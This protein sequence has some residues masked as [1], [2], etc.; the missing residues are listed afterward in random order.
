MKFYVII[1]SLLGSVLQAQVNNSL[2]SRGASAGRKATNIVSTNTP[3]RTPPNRIIEFMV[4]L[5]PS[6][7]VSVLSSRNPAVEYARA[8][9]AVP[10]GFDPEIPTPILLI[11]STSDG[12]AS[13]IRVMPAF[14]NVALRLGWVV[15]AADPPFGKPQNDSP[16]WR[17]A[18]TS[19]LLEH[20]H[21][22][23]PGSKK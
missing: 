8:A 22:N 13:S 1:L 15:I 5:S 10:L 19:S 16:P 3:Y 6:A 11:C 4:P 7:K 21:K 17:W 2:Q 9:I 23:W 12:D 18:M 20:I 14:T